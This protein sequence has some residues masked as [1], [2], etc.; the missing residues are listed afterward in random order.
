MTAPIK[1]LIEETMTALIAASQWAAATTATPT[2]RIPI[3]IHEL[4]NAQHS[5]HHRQRST[6]TR[7]HHDPH[8]ANSAAQRDH[9]PNRLP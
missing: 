6:L 3:S 9:P 5:P 4:L 7:H 2:I 1:V 8:P